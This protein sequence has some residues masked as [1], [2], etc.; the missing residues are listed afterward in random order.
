MLLLTSLEDLA[1]F[2]PV[3]EVL[4]DK[5][6]FVAAPA[7]VFEALPDEALKQEIAAFLTPWRAKYGDR[8]PN[9]AGRGWDGVM[10]TAAAVEKAKS[11]DGPALRDSLESIDNFQ[12]TT[13]IYHFSSDNHQ[14][15]TVNPLLLATIG[16]GQVKVVQ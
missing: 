15:I 12:G 16:N 14:G 10:L 6:F 8:D 7:Q 3:A 9:W 5:F 11:F 2:R 1:V 4:G 13:G